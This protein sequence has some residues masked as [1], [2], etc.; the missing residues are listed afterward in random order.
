MAAFFEFDRDAAARCP[1][2]R[3]PAREWLLSYGALA[4]GVLAVMLF[5]AACVVAVRS[6]V[7]V[8]DELLWG[9]ALTACVAAV[10]VLS[11]DVLAI[12]ALHDRHSVSEI[13]DCFGKA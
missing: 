3:V 13:T 10:L 11:L 8:A 7:S 2:E 9:L 12:R 6:G 5:A 1:Y 4:G